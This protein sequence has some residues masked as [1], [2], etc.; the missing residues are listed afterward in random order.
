[1]QPPSRN[2]RRAPC[3]TNPPKPGASPGC[4]FRTA[5]SCDSSLLLNAV[6][7]VAG[8]T[9]YADTVPEAP[10]KM[11]TC[12][13]SP[14]PSPLPGRPF[15]V[16]SDGGRLYICVHD[17]FHLQK[18]REF[19][20]MIRNAH[21]DRNRRVWAA[22]RTR[23]LLKAR[24]RW[25]QEETRWYARF[26]LDPPTGATTTRTPGR[27]FGQGRIHD[28]NSS[29]GATESHQLTDISML[30]AHPEAEIRC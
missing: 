3:Q 21:P 27:R 15:Y 9:P 8:S 18:Q 20:R 17:V 24:E 22:G 23:K 13:H 5:P 29:L 2:R 16:S 28:P 10:M 26:G 14:L 7:L 4:S 19:K 1:M 6:R 30:G 25:V 11:M 12:R